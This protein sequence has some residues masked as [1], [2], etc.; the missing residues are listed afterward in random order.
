MAMLHSS[1]LE[2]PTDGGAWSATVHRVAKSQTRLSDFNSLHFIPLKCPL[3]MYFSFCSENNI[4]KNFQRLNNAFLNNNMHVVKG[5]TKKH[6][7]RKEFFGIF[8]PLEIIVIIIILVIFLIIII[9][10]EKIF[11]PFLCRK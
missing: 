8:I 2:N 11:S 10:L 5:G 6:R 7:K 4:S 3:S 9:L 1:R